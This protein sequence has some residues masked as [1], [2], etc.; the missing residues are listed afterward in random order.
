METLYRKYRPQTFADVIGQGHVVTTLENAII[1]NRIGHA[2]LFAGPRGTGKTTLARIFA[3]AVNCQKR[4]DFMP[5][6][7]NVC[8]QIGTGQ[9][10]DII[11]IDAAS[12]TGVDNIRELRETVKLPPTEAI[13]KVYIIDE[14]HM[15]SQGAFNALL[16]TLEEP[17]AH[18]LFILAT[19]EI[20]KVPETILS[21]C[22]QFTF[23]RLSIEHII[24]KLSKIAKA[25]NVS[26]DQDAMET[27]AL[28]AEG[29]MRDAESL[30]AQVMALEDK[31]ITAKEVERILGTASPATVD[32]ILMAVAKK[33]APDAL[34]L[35]NDLSDHGYDLSV[36]SRIL[37]AQLR[38]ILLFSVDA[39]KAHN[40]LANEVTQTHEKVLRDCAALQTTKRVIATINAFMEAD[41]LMAHAPIPQLPLEIAIIKSCMEKQDDDHAANEGASPQTP[42]ETPNVSATAPTATPPASPPT[43]QP[44]NTRREAPEKT[45][46]LIVIDAVRKHWRDIV[47]EVRTSNYSLGGL[48]ANATL[49]DTKNDILTIAVSHAFHREKLHQKANQLTVENALGKILKTRLRLSAVVEKTEPTISHRETSEAESSSPSDTLLFALKTMG[50]RIIES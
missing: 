41:R 44:K 12:H 33:N 39:E 9:S 32:R 4:A 21:R 49:K 3:K 50:G 23:A 31:K 14:A 2:Y 27:I 45:S 6:A 43:P 38:Y 36:L 13:Y 16:K 40:I 30:L 34:A 11:E 24:K 46:S 5:C 7:K 20:H 1:H 25:E 28:T 48:L 29:G 15:L 22:Q 19:T 47:E 10:L 42:Q 8:E 17:P 37:I 26:V 35:V 18:A